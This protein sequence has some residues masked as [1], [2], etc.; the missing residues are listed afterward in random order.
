MIKNTFCWKLKVSVSYLLLDWRYLLHLYRLLSSVS[1]C[2]VG[3]IRNHFH[4]I[5]WV[6]FKESNDIFPF[7]FLGFL[8]LFV[9][10]T[11]FYFLI[12]LNKPYLWIRFVNIN[13]WISKS[14]ALWKD[15]RIRR[16]QHIS[17]SFLPSFIFDWTKCLRK[18][19]ILKVSISMGFLNKIIL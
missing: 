11:F 18:L 17:A 3:M 7:L 6:F 15:L 13:Q 14:L 10:H 9:N 1:W 5:V 2:V 16:N 12:F 4:Q 19:K 8:Q